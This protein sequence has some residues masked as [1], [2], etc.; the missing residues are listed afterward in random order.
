MEEE[1][2]IEE[3]LLEDD[4]VTIDILGLFRKVLKRWKFI[5]L[6]TLIF[7][8]LG[9]AYALKMKRTY[10]VTMTL[11]PELQNRSSSSLSTLASMLGAGGMALN[12]TP[13]A[14]NITLFPEISS[15]TPFLCSLL[16]VPVTPYVSKKQELE[17]VRPDTT[18]VFMHVLGRDKTL[19]PRKEAKRQ[20]AD[21]KYLYDDSVIDPEALTPRQGL[22]VRALR[23]A[24][25]T[26]V[27]NKTG[28]TTISVVMDDRMIVKQVADT[29]CQRLQDFVIAYRTKKAT[30]D[31]E[32]YVELAEEAHA[33][34]VKAQAAYA[35]RVD[36]DRSVILQSVSSARQRL[37]DEANLANQIYSQMAQQRE[38]AKAKIQEMKP[39][40]AVV[41]PASV[42]LKPSNS[43]SR[44]CII[45]FFMGFLLST[46]WVAFGEDLFK[47]IRQGVKEPEGEES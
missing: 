31:Y 28:V 26:T 39:V 42:P 33:R 19:S 21:A 32:Y 4:E 3:D 35:A 20:Q 17:G 41:Q 11:A 7:S 45:F 36:Y 9:V 37:Q 29:V 40:Y 14:L 46:L 6:V 34:L 2:I 18:T 23:K 1:Y 25:N 12:S 38:L 5:L 16:E 24:I 30:A 8:A 27:D 13:D 22:A 47:K 44:V 10:T 43:R 15:S